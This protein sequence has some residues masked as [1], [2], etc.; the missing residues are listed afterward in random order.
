VIPVNPDGASDEWAAWLQ[1]SKATHVAVTNDLLSQVREMF[2]AHHLSLP[3]IE[4][5]KKQGGEYATSFTPP[6]DNVPLDTDQVVLFRT[7]GSLGEPKFVPLTHKQLSHAVTCLRGVYRLLPTDRFYTPANWSHPFA[8]MHGM[9]F[10]VMLGNTSVIDHGEEGAALLNFIVESK[11]TRLIGFPPFFRKLLLLCRDEK[12]RIPAAVKT[13]VVGMGRLQPELVKAMSLMNVTVAH[14][15]GVTEAS[16]TLAMEEGRKDEEVGAAKDSG[17]AEAVADLYPGYLVGR[18]LAGLKYK[19]LDAAGDEITGR[20]RREGLLA[21]TGPSMMNGY[22][23]NE[24]ESKQSLRGTWLYTHE[25]ARLEGDGEELKIFYLGRKDDVLM[26]DGMA[27]IADPIDRAIHKVKGITDGA[28][29][30]LKTSKGES[31]FVVA[32]VRAPGNPVNE[33]QIIEQLAAEVPGSVLPAVAVFTDYIPRDFAGNVLRHKLR[34]QFS[35][36]LG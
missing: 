20:D 25:Y 18:G 5:E 30:L 1:D 15:Y 6:A 27:C 4:I 16:W 9:L 31:K 26:V 14:C 34:A 24:K 35:G 11:V 7:A 29:F 19:V 21:V 8:F 10:P 32:A 13:A 22:F 3:I 2:T 28:G 12:R 36:V 23:E 33:K 17:E